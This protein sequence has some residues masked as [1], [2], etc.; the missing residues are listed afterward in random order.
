M[1]HGVFYSRVAK[2]IVEK[3]LSYVGCEVV[4]GGGVSDVSWSEMFAASS[5]ELLLGS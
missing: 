4:S 2:D 5:R 1:R 3:H